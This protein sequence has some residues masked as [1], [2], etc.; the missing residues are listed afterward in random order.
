[1]RTFERECNEQGTCKSCKF[2]TS[3]I[4][5]VKIGSPHHRCRKPNDRLQVCVQSILRHVYNVDLMKNFLPRKKKI[6]LCIENS[7]QSIASP[8][9]GAIIGLEISTTV[10]FFGKRSVNNV[11]AVV[12]IRRLERR[13]GI[14][15]CMKT[16]LSQQRASGKVKAEQMW[17][18]DDM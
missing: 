12:E 14:D 16:G 10:G 13:A 8:T 2:I 15:Q 18:L 6:H 17:K 5:D 1:M 11:V 9:T 7:S 4:L 3:W